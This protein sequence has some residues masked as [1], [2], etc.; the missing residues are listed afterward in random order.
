[1]N[2]C[3][4]AYALGDLPLLLE[5]AMT[6][7]VPEQAISATKANVDTVFGLASKALQGFGMLVELNSQTVKASLAEA[8]EIAV[9]PSSPG[10]GPQAVFAM[11]TTQ[12]QTGVQKAQAYWK[13]VT[14][15]VSGTQAEFEDAAKLVFKQSSIEPK[16]WFD[17]MSKSAIPGGDAM[18]AFW[19]SSFGAVSQAA[20]AAYA[21]ATKATRKAAETAVDQAW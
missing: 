7:F 2:C 8:Q 5:I 3:N 12:L 19:K 17:T 4:A 15:I 6:T 9:Q 13:H 10:K 16:A 18:A 1:M 14:E 20:D 21:A 11:Q